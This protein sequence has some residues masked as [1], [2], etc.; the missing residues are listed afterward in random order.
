M[1]SPIRV[2]VRPT[3]K[4]SPLRVC[5]FVADF[6]LVRMTMFWGWVVL[7]G[8]GWCGFFVCVLGKVHTLLGYCNNYVVESADY[9][10]EQGQGFRF[11]WMEK[12]VADNLE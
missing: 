9:E 3:Y 2:E 10:S 5:R 1:T 8:V 11:Q 7:G 4:V 12:G 6:V